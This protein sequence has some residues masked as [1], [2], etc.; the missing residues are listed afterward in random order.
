MHVTEML[1]IIKWCN[2]EYLLML[3]HGCTYHMYITV[4]HSVHEEHG[5]SWK[6]L[7]VPLTVSFSH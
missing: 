2:L 4:Q 1:M 5:Q 7:I 6:F 3:A